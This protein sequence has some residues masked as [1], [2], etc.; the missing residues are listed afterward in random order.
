M[1]NIESP[2]VFGRK[3]TGE[4]FT[5]RETETQ[6]LLNNF[7]NRINTILIS[8]RRWGKS[9]LVKKAGNMAENEGL[10]VLFIDAFSLRDPSEFYATLATGVLKATSGKIELWIDM[11]KRFLS[12]LTPKFSFGAD[13]LNSF[14]LS[15]E[16]DEIEKGYREILDLPEKIADEKNIRIVI[17]IDEFQ[18]TALFQDSLLFHKRLRSAWQEHQQVTYCLYGSRQHMMAALFEKQSM[19]FYRFGENIFL[20]KIQMND[21]IAFIRERFSA[22][23][24]NITDEMASKI[25]STVDCHSYYVQQL[26]H[27]VWQRTY[28]TADD[29]IY[30]HACLD[31]LSQNE[32]LYLRETELL[33]ETQLHFLKA[34]AAGITENYNSKKVM[35][36]YKMGTSANISKIKKALQEKEIIELS[37]N[38]IDF[39]DPVYKLWFKRKILKMDL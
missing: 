8:P 35:S 23:G 13:P 7:N 37:N 28:H 15:F 4:S 32:I 19:P 16:L 34:V 39:V 38:K 12:R 2:F 5:D 17:C 11:V 26:S 20:E 1:N 25:A 31:L 9:S 22:T 10:T 24:K 33:S 21:W 18:N 29:T 27:L 14:E 30:N 36:E 3:V 6:R